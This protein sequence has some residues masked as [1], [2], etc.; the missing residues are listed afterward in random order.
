V[1]GLPVAVL[2]HPERF[3]RLV[4]MNTGV[5][6]GD[7]GMIEAWWAFRE[8]MAETDDPPVST[9][10]SALGDAAH[11]HDLDEQPDPWVAPVERGEAGL[12]L[13]RDVAAA[14]DAPF[15]TP[16]A[17]AGAR[18]WPSLVPTDPEMGGADIG[19]EAIE[20]LAAWEKPAFV[21]FGD[22]DPITGPGRDG[23]RELIP[24]AT[25][26]PDVW[27]DGAGHFLQ[28]EAGEAVAAEIVG[29]VDRT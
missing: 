21:L 9:A 15:H 5:P 25:E 6:S 7:G 14:Y 19:Q 3:A 12:D 29:F 4:P 2:E 23:L 28:E 18:M 27:V 22:E 13:D 1:L 20:A 17:K 8:Y 11:Y 24:T 10:I 26:Q 16:E